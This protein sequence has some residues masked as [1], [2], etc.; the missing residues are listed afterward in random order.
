MTEALAVM[1]TA[2][3]VRPAAGPMA[4]GPLDPW[5]VLRS[6]P[7]K[8]ESLWHEVQRRGIAVFYPFLVVKPVNPR[9]RHRRAYFPGY[10]FIHPQG[11]PLGPADFRWMPHAQGLVRFG[12]EPA[13]VPDSLITALRRRVESSNRET[14]HFLDLLQPGDRLDIVSGPLA[15]YDAIFDVRLPGKDRVRV[16]LSLLHDRYI[17]VELSGHT[18]E[19]QT[20]P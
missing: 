6:K 7:N 19:R 15:G 14:R 18:L 17:A 2:A 9:A 11:G 16:L 8:E 20:R 10:L 13:P 3:T 4:R 12:G 5:Y 1:S